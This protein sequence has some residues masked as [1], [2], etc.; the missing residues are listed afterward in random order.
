[1]TSVA[2]VKSTENHSQIAHKAENIKVGRSGN[3]GHLTRVNPM[4]Y[5]CFLPEEHGT[6]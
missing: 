2:L 5:F 6:I 4:L 1:M 3:I